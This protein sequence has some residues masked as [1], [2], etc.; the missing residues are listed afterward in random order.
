MSIVNAL[1]AR[2]NETK[3]LLSLSFSYL[4]IT[5]P[6]TMSHT[7]LSPEKASSLPLLPKDRNFEGGDSPASTPSTYPA[8]RRKVEPS[9]RQ[10]EEEEDALSADDAVMTDA[11]PIIPELKPSKWQGTINNVVK[12]IVSIRF[13]QVAAF[14]TEGLYDDYAYMLACRD[15]KQ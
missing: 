15:I 1:K 8:K 10:G 3:H 7:P 6:P 11:L 12:A 5:H 9:F 2:Q 14:D 13:S 4:S